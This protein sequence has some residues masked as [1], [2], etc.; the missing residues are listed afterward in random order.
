MDTDVEGQG[1]AV[2]RLAVIGL[3]GATPGRLKIG[4]QTVV[5][6]KAS[7]GAHARTIA[8]ATA[9]ARDEEEALV[10]NTTKSLLVSKG[11]KLC[12]GNNPKLANSH[13]AN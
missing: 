6:A 1:E 9:A 10:I 8:L 7:P 12:Y 13:R 11:Q 3:A 2:P 5:E 4:V